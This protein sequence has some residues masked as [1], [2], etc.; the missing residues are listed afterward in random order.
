MTIRWWGNSI[1]DKSL[2]VLKKDT[3]VLF[4]ILDKLRNP[5]ET[6]ETNWFIIFDTLRFCI[7]QVHV[8]IDLSKHKVTNNISN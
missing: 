7:P 4:C 6:T 1:V 2:L 5:I 8:K 3:T